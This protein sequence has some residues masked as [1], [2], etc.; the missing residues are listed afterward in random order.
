[1]N[2]REYK[3]HLTLLYS[4]ALFS[5]VVCVIVGVTSYRANIASQQR[6]EDY[7]RK[8]D[9]LQYD[10]DRIENGLSTLSDIRSATGD[11]RTVRPETQTVPLSE[12]SVRGMDST[13]ADRQLASYRE[14]LTRLGQIIDSSGLEQLTAEGDVD[15]SSLKEMSDER[16]K[17]RKI[18]SHFRG[19]RERNS[20]LLSADEK[21]YD[22]GMQSLYKKAS[23]RDEAAESAFNEMLEEYPDA[24]ATAVLIGQRAMDSISKDDV[25]QVEEYHAM[26]LA[27]RNEDASSVVTARGIEVMPAIEHYLV[28][29]YVEQGDTAEAELLVDS[30]EQNYPDSLVLSLINEVRDLVP[31]SEAIPVLNALVESGGTGNCDLGQSGDSCSDDSDCCSDKCTGDSGEETCR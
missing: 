26:L 25:T 24:Y 7:I 8:L 2:G 5:I 22:K 1:M 20:K 11:R 9:S 29:Q 6:E 28:T 12:N 23:S 13:S 18:A 16:V 31:V 27:S 10:I 15:L 14:E 21:E 3:K 30:L 4:V 17:G 19:L